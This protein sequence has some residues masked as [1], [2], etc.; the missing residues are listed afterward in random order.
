MGIVCY[1]GLGDAGTPLWGTAASTVVNLALHVLFMGHYGW[2][3]LGAGWA[4]VGRCSL[5]PKL[6][7][8]NK[9]A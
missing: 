8:L 7:Y 9:Y 5:N 4:V 2:G 1:R 3:V 6:G